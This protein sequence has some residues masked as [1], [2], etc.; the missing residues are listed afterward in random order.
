MRVFLLLII[1]TFPG[2][3]CAESMSFKLL[4]GTSGCPG[5]I[6]I[7]AEGEIKGVTSASFENFI[8]SN[9]SK[10]DKNTTVVLNSPGGNLANG[11]ELGRLIRAKGFNTH[12]ANINTKSDAILFVKGV[13]ASSCAYAFLGGQARSIHKDSKFGLHQ[14]SSSTNSIISLSDSIELTQDIIARIA[15][16][17]E[18]MGLPAEVVTIASRTKSEAIHWLDKNDLIQLQIVNSKGLNEQQP[19]HR[20]SSALSPT[21]AVQSLAADG[22]EDLIILTC[23]ELPSRGKRAGHV[24]FLLSPK[25][26][27]FNEHP[28]A[29][30]YAKASVFVAVDGELVDQKSEILFFDNG[31]GFSVNVQVP[32]RVVRASINR[33]SELTVKFD[34]P[35]DLDRYISRH[36]H[37]IP[38]DGLQIA[39]DA[40]NP[41]CPHFM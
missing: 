40:I 26:F 21:W 30:G 4:E 16:Y 31:G 32:V 29:G 38:L 18:D 14:I 39:L 37:S 36:V 6:L 27:Q 17:L 35:L 9:P 11:L 7:M 20:V 3:L 13:C 12:I 25:S 15:V 23:S 8:N 34:Y 1:S 10:F 28:Y 24:S 41:H 33:N 5:C 19:W 2:L 22:T